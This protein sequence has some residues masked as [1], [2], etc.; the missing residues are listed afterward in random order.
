MPGKFLLTTGVI[1]KPKRHLWKPGYWLIYMADTAWDHKP[2]SKLF[3]SERLVLTAWEMLGEPW[4][5]YQLTVDYAWAR[6]TEDKEDD[7]EG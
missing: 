4:H 2:V 6:W 3:P 1:P 5:P 7:E